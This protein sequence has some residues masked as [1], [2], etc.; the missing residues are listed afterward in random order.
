[1]TAIDIGADIHVAVD[2]DMHIVIDGYVS[3]ERPNKI[4]HSP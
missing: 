3:L 2:S 1:V 4:S